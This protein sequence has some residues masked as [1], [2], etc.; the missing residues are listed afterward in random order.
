M[1]SVQNRFSSLAAMALAAAMVAGC[2]SK[3]APPPAPAQTQEPN[4]GAA[5]PAPAQQD[6]S[7]A[8]PTA[9]VP[10]APANA[11]PAPAASQ[12]AVAGGAPAGPASGPAAAPAPV[13]ATPPPPAV[14][15]LARGTRLRVRLDDD[16]GSKISQPGQ[17]F[18]CTIADPV[19]VN[20]QTVIE[21]GARAEGTVVDAKA[22]GRFKG[23]A[24]LEVRLDRVHTKWG[25]YP[26]ATESIERAEKGK[27]QR[28]AGFIGGGAGL[29]ALIGGL[30]GGGKG[31][32]IGALAGA[33][34]GTAGTALTGNQNI[35][36]PAETLLTFRLEK[37]VHIT[38]DN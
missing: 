30:A 38:Q 3:T 35:V 7:T 24:E 28:S 26:V 27:G 29:G 18:R 1:I 36:L 19:V 2:H 14:V 9:A 8:S 5:A 4:A 11:V 6:G 32:G 31:A 22:L 21:R 20:G 34:A 16:L 12:Q 33:G 23:G 25:R 37:P 17:T 13:P 15:S 10:P